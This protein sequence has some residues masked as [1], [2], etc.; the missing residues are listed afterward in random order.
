MTTSPDLTWFPHFE[1]KI[2]STIVAPIPFP[3]SM[4]HETIRKLWETNSAGGKKSAITAKYFVLKDTYLHS[5]D[6]TLEW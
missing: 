6:V 2:F 3:V 4:V 1:E 5:T